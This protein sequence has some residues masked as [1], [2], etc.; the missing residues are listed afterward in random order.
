MANGQVTRERERE[1][2]SENS[3]GERKEKQREKQ[4]QREIPLRNST[5]REHC[6]TEYE[7]EKSFRNYD[8]VSRVFGESL[9]KTRDG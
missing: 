8:K 5:Q 6:T 3:T 9:H 7:N 1:R 2:E 4:Q